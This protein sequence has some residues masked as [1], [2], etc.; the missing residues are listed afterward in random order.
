[1]LLFR[2]TV[3]SYVTGGGG[4]RGSIN[5]FLGVGGL[6]FNLSQAQFGEGNL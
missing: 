2:V 1:M 4:G 5:S 3:A 6:I